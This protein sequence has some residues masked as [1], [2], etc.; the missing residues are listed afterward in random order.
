MPAL[1]KVEI[2]TNPIEEQMAQALDKIVKKE[3]ETKVLSR[4]MFEF[5][6]T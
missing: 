2:I 1:P 5:L 4:L 6:K 3:L